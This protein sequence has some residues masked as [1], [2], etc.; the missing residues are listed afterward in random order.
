MADV[1][2]V[3]DP[4]D[5]DATPR[6]VKRILPHLAQDETFVRMFLQEARI[7]LAIDHP[8]VVRIH[9]LDEDQGLPYLLMDHIDGVTFR[10]IARA[11]EAAGGPVPTGVALD[12]VMQACTGAHAVHETVVGDHAEIVH[13]DLC[14]HN[15]MVDGAGHVLLLDFG[16]AKAA[17]G[18]DTTRTGVLKG[19]T[20]YLAPEQVRGGAIDR[21][22][23]L[24]ALSIVLWELLAGRRAFDGEAE[25][26]TMQRI[27]R[28]D[29]PRLDA[30]RPDLPSALVETV[31]RCLNA[32]RNE[33][34]PDAIALRE[35]L[36]RAAA[37]ADIAIDRAVTAAF[38]TRV[39]HGAPPLLHDPVVPGPATET[40]RTERPSTAAVAGRAAAW[41]VG[42]G[43]AAVAVFA[44]G[45][46]AA[47]WFLTPT[48]PSGAPIR[49]TF[50]PILPAEEMAAELEPLRA[51]L[52]AAIDRPVQIQIAPSYAATGA[53]LQAGRTEFAVLP[54]R[55]F[56]E[57]ERAL[58]GEL[59]PLVI[60]EADRSTGT[61]GLLIARNDV[62][63]TGPESLRGRT[64]CLADP[65][66]AT[67]Y[68]L[69]MAWMAEHGI[70]PRAD[71]AGTVQSADH[72][73][74]IRD[75]ATG[76][77]DV[78]ATYAGA[79]RSAADTEVPV[80]HTR[81]V[82]VTGHTPN[83][84]ICAGPATDPALADAVRA[85]LLA[86]DP[87]VTQGARTIGVRQRISGFVPF[88]PSAHDALRR[89]LDPRPPGGGAPDPSP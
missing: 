82:A 49:V 85:A 28:G 25:F 33:R 60:V 84:T 12:L 4:G 43:I 83:D 65:A 18:M 78:G 45:A 7:A 39:L 61:D 10:Q 54:P 48:G 3:V 16:I 56:L 24:W 44:V 51:D 13:R 11:A 89:A 36:S 35:A 41:T 58:D 23:D 5:D 20:T 47:V 34:F 1:Y 76:R 71:L 52:E 32:D 63:W 53:L 87:E 72:H 88:D 19:K 27:V 64:L 21:R 86:W 66:S 46:A 22:T 30:A 8:N 67:G 50:A 69:P 14:P 42:F 55:L 31:H 40:P 38:V 37:R 17:Q 57:A 80:Q 79:V 77:C 2:L 15:L 73:Q 68:A 6:V 62:P 9:R 75:V 70:D 74:I 26:D 29:V 59:R 81:Q